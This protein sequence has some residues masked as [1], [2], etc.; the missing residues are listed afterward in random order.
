MS[1]PLPTFR[2]PRFLLAFITA[3]LLVT[4][5]TFWAIIPLYAL[6]FGGPLYLIA[7][8]PL[9]AWY[10]RRYPFRALPMLLLAQACQLLQIPLFGV[11][12]LYTGD[13]YMLTPLPAF[14]TFG[15]L[16]AVI[17]TCAFI[18]LYRLLA[19]AEDPLS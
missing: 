19:K 5:L 18:L 13:W 2:S 9:A 15:A 6:I 11:F 7:G 12:A 3:P 10:L 8:L 14:V 16:F 4:L 17:W 1:A